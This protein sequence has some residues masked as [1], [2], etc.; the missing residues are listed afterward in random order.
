[1]VKPLL[2]MIVD[3]DP[4]IL[5]V[6]GAVLERRGH[7]V[8]KRSSAIGTSVAISREQPDVVLLD[9]NMPGLSGDRLARLVQPGG[10]GPVVI[11]FSGIFEDELEELARTCGAAGVIAKNGD[12]RQLVAQIER[13]ARPRPSLAPRDIG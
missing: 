11:L 12:Q 5:Q 4:M 2:V 10:S 13:L 1:M 3:D 8:L 9:V 6:T 7:R